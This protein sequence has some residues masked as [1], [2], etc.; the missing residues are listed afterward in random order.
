[1]DLRVRRKKDEGRMSLYFTTYGEMFETIYAFEESTHLCV[2]YPV[3][4]GFQGF[5]GVALDYSL[6]ETRAPVHGVPH[7]HVQVVVT[8]LGC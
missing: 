8:L 6:H 2:D 4:D 5:I 1:M 7:G 3:Y